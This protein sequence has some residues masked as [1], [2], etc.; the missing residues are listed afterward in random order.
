M[1]TFHATRTISAPPERIWR[2]ITNAPNYPKWEPWTIRIE[3]VIA[4]QE[5]ITAYTKLSPNRA[6]PAKVAVFEPPRRMVWVGGM[7]LGLFKGEREFLLEPRSDG[8][9]N[10]TLREE[11]SGLLAPLLGRS[12]PDMTR[13]FEDF[14][15][16][17]KAEAERA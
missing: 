10:F 12:I 4:P 15:A 6:F 7:P 2:I 3:G 1:K 5:T 14:V 9:V 8:A 11:F 16:A 17:L 13:P